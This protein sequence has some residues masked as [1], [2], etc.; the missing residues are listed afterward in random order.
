MIAF[1]RAMILLLLLEAGF[2][3]LLRVYIRSLRREKLEKL[4][5]RQNPDMA[6][7]NPQ[8]EAYLTRE[9]ADFETSLRT[10]LLWLVFI[11][12]TLTVMGIVYLVNWQ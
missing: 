6:G 1:L 2:Y 8:R 7:D 11:L 12:P 5:D 4:W 9:M 3:L 10:R